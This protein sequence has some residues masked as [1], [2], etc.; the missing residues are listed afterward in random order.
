MKPK[1]LKKYFEK[2]KIFHQDFNKM[3]NSNIL[4][5]YVV[6]DDLDIDEFNFDDFKTIDD[7]QKI[8]KR[9]IKWNF[10]DLVSFSSYRDTWTYIIGKEG[11][12]VSNNYGGSGYLTIPYEI[13]KYLDNVMFKYK[14]MDSL[15]F[16]DIRNDDK[17]IQE[18][19]GILDPKNKYT[20]DAFEDALIININQ[21]NSKCFAINTKNQKKWIAFDNCRNNYKNSLDQ[22]S[23]KM[24]REYFGVFNNTDLFY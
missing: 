9:K 20:Y 16:I 22:L 18:H 2:F 4:A 11:K 23:Y 17:W 14:N 1:I 8:S 15:E 5:D 13:S 24:I 6:E 3:E 10:G 12:L 21:Q 7:V 19:F